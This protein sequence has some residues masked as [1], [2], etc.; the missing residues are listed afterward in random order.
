[1]I[2]KTTLHTAIADCSNQSR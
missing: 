2:R 1:V